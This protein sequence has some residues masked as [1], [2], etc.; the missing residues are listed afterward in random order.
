MH[1]REIYQSYKEAFAVQHAWTDVADCLQKILNIDWAERTEEQELIVERILT[2]TRNVLRVPPNVE[3]EKRSDNDASLHDQLLWAL[4]QAGVLDLIL[5]ILGSEHEHQYHL[6]ALEIV[7]LVYREQSA[8]NLAGASQQRDKTGIQRVEQD[9]TMIRKHEKASHKIRVPTVRHSLFGGTYVLQNLKSTSDNE[10]VCH[11]SLHKALEINFDSDKKKNKKSFRHVHET[12]SVERKSAYSVRLFLREYC[13]EILRSSFNNIVRQT[14]RILESA[15]KEAGGGHDDSY[16]LWAIR[17]FMEFN[18]GCGFKLDLVSESLSVQCF[19]WIITRVEYYV[20]MI[21]SDKTHARLWSRRLH[22]AVQAYREMLQSLQALQ[23]LPDAKAKDLFLMLQNNIFYVLEYREIILHLL[24]GFNETNNTRAY[25]YDVIETAHLFLKM[26]EKYCQGTVRVQSK[27]RFKQR[28]NKTNT[29]VKQKEHEP[30]AEALEEMWLTMAGQISTCLVNQI[31]LPEEDHPIPFDAAS[32][33]SID[34]QKGA[35]M[36][37]IHTLLRDGKYEQAI[38][39]LRSGREIWPENDFFGSALSAPEDELMILKEIFLAN[40]PRVKDKELESQLDPIEERYDEDYE[41]EDNQKIKEAD[42]KFEDF[43][44]RLLNPKV[45][46]SCTIALM[47]WK[48]IETS[49]LKAAVTI[50]HRI[51]VGCKMPAMLFQAS[52]FRIFQRV[53]NSPKDAHQLE[54]RRLGVY[55]VQKFT[56]LAASNPKIYAELLFYKSIKEANAIEM[57]YEDIYGNNLGTGGGCLKGAWSEEQEEEL[58]QLYLENQAN[59]ATDQDVIDWILDNLIDKHRTRRT[60]IK[61][62]K[63]LG[64]IFKAPTK[65]SNAMALNKNLWTQEQDEKLR[66]LYDEYRLNENVLSIIVSEFDGVRSKQSILNR[67]VTIGLIADKS[68]IKPKKSRSKNDALSD[69]ES[70]S[71]N[72]FSEYKPVKSQSRFAVPKLSILNNKRFHVLLKELEGSFKEAIEWLAE[73]FS[74]AYEDYQDDSE[75]RDDGVP[76]VPIMQFQREALDNTQFK[77][78]LTELGLEAPSEN[79]AYWRIPATMDRIEL[80]LRVK[81]LNDSDYLHIDSVEC[82]I[83][84]N[85]ERLFDTDI[86]AN[87]DYNME[88]EEQGLSEDMLSSWRNKTNL[89]YS[90]SDLDVGMR[91]PLKN[92]S[93]KKNPSVTSNSNKTNTRKNNTNKIKKKFNL[94][95]WL[96]E[97]DDEF[98]KSLLLDKHVTSN[99]EDNENS[100]QIRSNKKAKSHILLPSDSESDNEQL[101]LFISENDSDDGEDHIHDSGRGA[102]AA[103][104]KRIRSDDSDT[105]SNDHI[106]KYSKQRRRVLVIDDQDD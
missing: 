67:M 73:S 87:P 105:D 11:H 68:E 48:Q 24:I 61:K 65:K 21:R 94:I 20:D 34:D 82:D 54:L 62:L 14:R 30:D 46:R 89:L 69:S 27:Q 97:S 56:T 102:T 17:F 58:R 9:L 77:N 39:L 53:F 51:A 98:G 78:L 29:A 43:A 26:L 45:V 23:M 95:E 44:N 41:E 35:C 86:I 10:L 5:Y 19:H 33:I 7:S 79:E 16:L 63:E 88:V 93:S 83:D 49:S 70:E 1:L 75:D 101:R 90:R 32:D 47:D 64:L 36:I 85:E 8:S 52:L 80:D 100:D 92:K 74:E 104:I 31:T 59:P 12:G 60:V 15:V 3:R 76:L 103:R 2:L 4:H 42:F 40:L 99:T 55:I 22:V 25:L 81:L 106:Q 57:G 13:I 28:R 71:D 66:K 37:R 96:N 18:R 6:H 84:R 38:I 91:E 72:D 50:L